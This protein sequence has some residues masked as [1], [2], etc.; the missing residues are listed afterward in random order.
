MAAEDHPDEVVHDE[1]EYDTYS[2]DE[3][4]YPEPA[5]ESAVHTVTE[6]ETEGR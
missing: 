6:A 2:D 4:E 1:P 3:P 5:E